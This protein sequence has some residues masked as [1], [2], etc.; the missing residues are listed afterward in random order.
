MQSPANTRR[1]PRYPVN[2]PVSVL[3]C[4]GSREK[5]VS[6][7]GIEIS[8]G[9]MSLYAGIPLQPGDLTEIE[10]RHPHNARLTAVV[11]NRTGYWF[12]LE[13]ISRLPS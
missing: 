5:Q 11:R 13:F 4:D 9:G 8:E 10:F 7:L 12:G 3:L 1:W 6:G 2:L